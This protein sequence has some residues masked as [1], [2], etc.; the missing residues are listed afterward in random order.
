[1]I[2]LIGLFFVLL[3]TVSLEQGFSLNSL[4]WL[5]FGIFLVCSKEI[6]G[7]FLFI[8]REKVRAQYRR[9]K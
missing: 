2:K 6:V 8:E 7:H 1:M 3:S 5:L 4:A 9:Q